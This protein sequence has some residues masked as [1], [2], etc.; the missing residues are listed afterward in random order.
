ME[1]GTSDKTRRLVPDPL[2]ELFLTYLL[3]DRNLSRNT[4]ATYRRTFA[5]IPDLAD[6]DH[7]RIEQWWDGRK[8][9]APATRAN[10]L[11][12]VRSFYRWCRIWD[13][14]DPQD[15]PTYRLTAPK[16]GSRVPRPVGR[17]DLLRLLATDDATMRRAFCL[18]AY[19]GL[20]IAEVAALVWPDVD[21]ED[22]RIYVRGKGDKDRVVGLS[23]VL[24]DSLL[25]AH[26]G[27]VVTGDARRYTANTLQQRVN[28]EMRRIGVPG[29]FHKLRSRYATVAL[30]STGNLLAVSRALGHSSPSTTAR[31]AASSSADLDLIAEAVVK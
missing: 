30:G 27:N 18:G 19:A 15:D 8:D 23:S 29:T 12:A 11:A 5:T 26:D 14:R 25:P 22:M 4:V 10:E 31:Y 16:Q 6:A 7:L 20:R 28:A 24:L 13:H 21:T 1:P 9:K 17:A 2:T 3:T